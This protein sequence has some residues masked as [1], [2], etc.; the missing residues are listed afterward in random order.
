MIQVLLRDVL[1][2]EP[3]SILGVEDLIIYL[4]CSEYKARVAMEQHFI[5]IKLLLDSCHRTQRWHNVSTVTTKCH[6]WVG[7]TVCLQEGQE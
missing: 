3:E 1:M 4:E 5:S 6:L 7:G 2:A